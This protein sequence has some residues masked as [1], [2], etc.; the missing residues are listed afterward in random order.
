MSYCTGR[1]T[2]DGGHCCWLAGTVCEFLVDTETPG[3]GRFRCAL[4]VELGSWE[5]V[6]EDPRYR[7]IR[8]HFVGNG[9]GLCG[10]WQP[11]PGEC[12]RE[13]R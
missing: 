13:K 12:C 3:P 6:Y 4:R 2:A 8:D 1:G 10:D 5:V 9:T 7:P 11:R